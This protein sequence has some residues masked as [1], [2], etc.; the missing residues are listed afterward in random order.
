MYSPVDVSGIQ[1]MTKN[2][3][4]SAN[5]SQRRK[6]AVKTLTQQMQTVSLRKKKTPFADVGSILGNSVGSM[7]GL[8]GLKGV[9]KWLGSGI[10]SIFGSGDYQIMGS[11]PSYNVLS[12]SSQIPK[13]SSTAQ[14]NIV[15]HREYLGDISGTTAFTNNSYPLN[16][17]QAKTFPWLSTIAQNYQQYKWHGMIFEFRPLITDFVTSGAPGV[18]VMA[19]NYNADEPAYVTKQAMENSEYAVSVKPTCTLIHGVECMSTQTVLPQSYI[20]NAAAN[21]NLDLKFSDLGNFQLATQGN[22]TQLIGELWVSYTVEFFKPILPA[23]VGG[24]VLSGEVDRQSVSPGAPLGTIQI[25]FSGDLDGYLLTPTSISWLGQP[26]NLYIVNNYW[27][28]TI[29]AAITHP[30]AT[31]VNCAPNNTFLLDSQPVLLAP[32][33][34]VVST[35]AISIIVVKCTATTA[36]TCTINFG[37]AGA[38]PT[39]TTNFT[40]V[41]TQLS[42]ALV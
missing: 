21:P 26:G 13:F 33:N 41:V 27:L 7:V 28:G 12:N 22:P 5:G 10:G 11:N 3:N 20:R 37:V 32:V 30:I 14:T 2:K 6:K 38:F 35:S 39:G 42:T 19:T 8:P 17:G 1:Y 18:V 4:K 31:Y 24:D 29:A 25:A 40:N 34:G 36:T 23:D 16:P 9:G 15:S